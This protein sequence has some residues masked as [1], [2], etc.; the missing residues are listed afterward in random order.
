MILFMETI[1]VD[2]RLRCFTSAMPLMFA[3]KNVCFDDDIQILKN[4]E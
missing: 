3:I 1:C 2:K 4:D